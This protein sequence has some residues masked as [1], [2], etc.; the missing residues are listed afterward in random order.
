MVFQVFRQDST[1]NSVPTSASCLL[2]WITT[3]ANWMFHI[4]HILPALLPPKCHPTWSSSLAFHRAMPK[5]AKSD[6]KV[7]WPGS[8]TWN[9]QG[10]CSDVKRP[11]ACMSRLRGRSMS[12]QYYIHISHAVVCLRCV[13]ESCRRKLH[14]LCKCKCVCTQLQNLSYELSWKLQV[15]P[16][17]D[18][19]M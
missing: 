19:I 1:R 11:H 12:I 5:S 9:G 2:F 16:S 3:I 13:F 4:L 17:I 8:T 14:T 18:I 10:F 15:H 6:A 7:T